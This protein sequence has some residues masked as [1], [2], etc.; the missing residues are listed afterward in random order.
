MT[1]GPN[2]IP[3]F[4]FIVQEPP[5]NKEEGWLFRN[6]LFDVTKGRN[7]QANSPEDTTGKEEL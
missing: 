6:V 5:N 4:H 2:H 3:K 1:A 7:P